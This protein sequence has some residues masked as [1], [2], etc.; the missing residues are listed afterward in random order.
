MTFQPTMT[1]PWLRDDHASYGGNVLLPLIR[2]HLISFGNLV[3]LSRFL[4][5]RWS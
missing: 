1:E 4:S 3:S 2:T 5:L